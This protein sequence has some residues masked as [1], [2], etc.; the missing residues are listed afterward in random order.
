M[1]APIWLTSAL[2][3]TM[4][5]AMPSSALDQNELMQQFNTENAEGLALIKQQKYKDAETKFRQLAARHRANPGPKNLC[6]ALSLQGLALALDKQDKGGDSWKV[7]EE[8]NTLLA[9]G[10]AQT[11][12]GAP[13]AVGLTAVNGAAG[14]TLRAY[15]SKYGSL[16]GMQARSA[17]TRTKLVNSSLK[18]NMRCVQIAAESY[19]T[20]FSHYPSKL[21]RAFQSY[22]IDGGNDGKRPGQ[23][24]RNPVTKTYEWP[25][26]LES[27][28]SKFQ[29]SAGSVIYI[30]TPNGKS[31]SIYGIGADGKYILDSKTSKTLVYTGTH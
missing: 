29:A 11:A 10:L 22:F 23:P 17:E 25:Q 31:Y 12:A 30:V 1:K 13:I 3:L 6:L 16:N 18:A 27:G 20:D 7:T 19:N 9:Q 28:Q 15:E 14:S 5:T 21:D 26:V 24:L 4:F 2:V 8:A